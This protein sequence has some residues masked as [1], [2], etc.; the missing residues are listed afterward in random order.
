MESSED[1]SV[2]G[3]ENSDQTWEAE[4]VGQVWSWRLGTKAG[5]GQEGNHHGEP[6]HDLE[7]TRDPWGIANQE[8]TG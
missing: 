1:G 4:N 2:P 5:H 6:G 8:V 3:G 7:D